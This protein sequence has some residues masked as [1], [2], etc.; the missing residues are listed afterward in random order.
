MY[1]VCRLDAA[2][3]VWRFRHWPFQLDPEG[4]LKA[5]L[6]ANPPKYNTNYGATRCTTCHRSAANP[7]RN[8]WCTWNG[9]ALNMHTW[10]WVTRWSI[11]ELRQIHNNGVLRHLDKLVLQGVCA[12]DGTRS[13]CVT[14]HNNPPHTRR[15]P[16]S[17]LTSPAHTVHNTGALYPLARHPAAVL[18]DKRR[19]PAGRHVIDHRCFLVTCC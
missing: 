6:G 16:M 7:Q 5:T 9:K 8:T 13:V 19:C 12:N 10:G 1:P 3:T 17:T 4:M 2:E 11:M 18:G 14:S 15:N